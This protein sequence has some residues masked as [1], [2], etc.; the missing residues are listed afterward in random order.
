MLDA[1][2]DQ[3]PSLTQIVIASASEAISG[4]PERRIEIASSR[5]TRLA[6]TAP[7]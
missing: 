4:L 3:V 2:F 1:S 5:K 6:M 7:T